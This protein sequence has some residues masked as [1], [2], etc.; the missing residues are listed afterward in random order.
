MSAIATRVADVDRSQ[1][2][3]ETTEPGQKNLKTILREMEPQLRDVYPKHLD[4]S[5]F[6][7]L[8]VNE[9][10]ST[11]RLAECTAQS[12]IAHIVATIRC[13]RGRGKIVKGSSSRCSTW[14]RAPGATFSAAV[15]W[16][17]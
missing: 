14:A 8:A 6:V 13:G 5:R 11:P 15:T 4:L 2:A 9:V 3:G 10:Q 16:S 1:A 7:L 17:W 12:V